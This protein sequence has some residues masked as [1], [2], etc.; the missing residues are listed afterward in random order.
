MQD[1]RT[2]WRM[3]IDLGVV[4]FPQ[5]NTDVEVNGRITDI[6]ETGFGVDIPASEL[7]E[8][9]PTKGDSFCFQFIDK[10]KFRGEK[11]VKVI[12]AQGV[13]IFADLKPGI[14]HLGCIVRDR[15]YSEYVRKRKFSDYYEQKTG[16]C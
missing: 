9:H 12:S 2:Y 1:R 8:E 14:C 10:Y 13:V 7:T 3:D 15:K 6:S 4:I 11:K 5:G 16:R